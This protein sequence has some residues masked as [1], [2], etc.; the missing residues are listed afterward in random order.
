MHRHGER[1][2]QRR[3]RRPIALFFDGTKRDGEHEQRG[4]RDTVGIEKDELFQARP[5][6]NEHR[7]SPE[8]PEVG[9][10][11][12]AAAQV[13]E[14]K[15]ETANETDEQCGRQPALRDQHRQGRKI[16]PQRPEMQCAAEK[17]PL[18]RIGN[19]VTDPVGLQE[20]VGGIGGRGAP[21]VTRRVRDHEECD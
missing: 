12:L 1:Q 3:E 6:R 18:E 14:R 13:G 16:E 21:R 4:R 15:F 19:R 20:L 7:R 11:E 9:V 8:Q 5:S 17:R 2:P 10:D